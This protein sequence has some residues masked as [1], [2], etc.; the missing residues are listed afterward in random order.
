[1]SR[2]GRLLQL[3]QILRGN[4]FPVKGQTL[5]DELGVSL[6]TL[7]RD[8][9]TLQQQGASIE[10]ES[11]VGYL[12]RP[13]FMLPP[14]VFS[15]EEL[16]ALVLGMRWVAQQGDNGLQQAARQAESKIR[17]VLPATLLDQM[18]SSGLLVVPAA[19]VPSHRVDIQ[20]LRQAIRDEQRIR[21]DY[22]DEKGAATAR[23]IW[24]FAL[25]YFERVRVLVAW[26]ELRQDF[27]HF[28]SDRIQSW[29]SLGERYPQRRRELLRRW[30]QSV[31]P[32]NSTHSK[33]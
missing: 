22:C 17:A 32:D 4:R 11:G 30:R 9:A 10:G 18:D 1:M 8:I 21:L 7:Y 20:P 29:Q 14:M 3:L 28:R 31:F 19:S 24:P 23:Y 33:K 13:G 26:C 16:E 6:R 25:G 2:A 27:R 5:A 12:L 15:A